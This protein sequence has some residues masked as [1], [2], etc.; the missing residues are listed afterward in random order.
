MKKVFHVMYDD[1]DK[2]LV[3]ARELVGKGIHVN[4][5]FSPFP[6]HGI[7]PIIGIKRTRL[8]IT[9]FMYAMTGLSLAVFFMWYTMISDW[10]MNIGGKPNFSLLENLPSFIPVSFEFSVFC[11]AH[12]MVITYL[13]RNRTLPGMPATNPDPRTTDDKFVMEITTDTNAMSAEDLES[14]IKNTGLLELSI[15]DFK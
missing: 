12:G 6:I 3:A 7:D 15:K 5:V 2:L 13:L 14:A 4:E 10:P 11:A 9:S 8:A 1:D